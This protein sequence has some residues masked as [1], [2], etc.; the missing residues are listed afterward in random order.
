MGL[1]MDFLCRDKPVGNWHV[2]GLIVVNLAR[3]YIDWDKICLIRIS[4]W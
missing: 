3:G 2:F 4:K 1:Y